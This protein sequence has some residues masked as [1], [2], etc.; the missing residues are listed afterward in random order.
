MARAV[1]NGKAYDSVDVQV[2]IAGVPIDVEEI[3]Y[4]KK[5]EHQNNYSL[6]SKKPTSW[7]MGKEEY[8]CTITI[9]MHAISPI[10]KA[11]GGDLTKIKPFAINVTFVNDYNDIVN[12]TII[13]KFQNQG[14][15]VTG[16]MGLKKQYE[17]FVL[18]MDLNNL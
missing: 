11:A 2:T 16:D 7:S 5:Q 13:A 14:R 15:E 4:E 18:D 8:S 10:E 6:G 9:P 17:L 3:T 1:I 12:D